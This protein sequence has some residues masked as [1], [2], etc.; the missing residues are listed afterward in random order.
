MAGYVPSALAIVRYDR[1][2]H[3]AWL[4]RGAGRRRGGLAGADAAGRGHEQRVPC[5]NCGRLRNPG[6]SP[7]PHFTA[8]LPCLGIVA[9]VRVHR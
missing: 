2:A 5:L 6:S 4:S 3:D 9:Y 7:A 8:R 1:R